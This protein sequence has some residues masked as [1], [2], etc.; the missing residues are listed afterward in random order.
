MTYADGSWY[1]GDWDCG[2]RHGVGEFHQ[3]RDGKMTI[4]KGQWINDLKH[5]LGKET[6][7]EKMFG[8]YQK[9]QGIWYHNQ[10]NGVVKCDSNSS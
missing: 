3:L 2:I 1:E 8:K 10:L 5:G 6:Y 7:P 4:Y 9:V